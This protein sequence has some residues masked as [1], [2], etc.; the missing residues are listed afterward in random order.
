MVMEN[1]V[2]LKKI[3][4]LA[5]VISGNG[6]IGTDKKKVVFYKPTAKILLNSLLSK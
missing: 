1:G 6:T 3:L 5:I 2:N 4:K